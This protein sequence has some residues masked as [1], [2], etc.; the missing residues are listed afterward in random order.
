MNRQ[1]QSTWLDYIQ[2]CSS[3]NVLPEK[4]K[5]QFTDHIVSLNRNF[6]ALFYHSVPL[7]YLLDYTT[8]KYLSMSNSSEKILGFSQKEFIQS[9]LALTLDLYEKP[10][11]E[12]I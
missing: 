7:V 3:L 6:L 1:K 10:A 8:S 12:S 11:F 4:I 9:G 5:S 2:N